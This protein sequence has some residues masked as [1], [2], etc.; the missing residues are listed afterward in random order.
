MKKLIIALGALATACSLQA[1]S[2]TWGFGNSEIKA[3]DGNY[4][5]EGSYSDA[6]AFL[7]LGTVTLTKSGF[8]FGT[9]TLL[10][11]MQGM[12]TEYNWA[13]ITAPGSSSSDSVSADGGQAYTLILVD[14]GGVTSLDT[15]KDG[16][17][18]VSTG[19]S[20]GMSIPGAA[21]TTYYASFVDINAYG[22][23][24]WQAVNTPEPTS[25]LLLL[26][27]FAGLALKRKQA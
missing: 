21:A 17:A 5:G 22:A 10:T 4:F 15:F 20:T 9:A 6:S 3:K 16:N 19:T 2:F 18:I 14:Q 11:S 8:D 7:Y 1:A 12:T 27:G 26:L 24:D 23:S 13:D 25:G